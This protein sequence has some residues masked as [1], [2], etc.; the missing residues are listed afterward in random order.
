MRSSSVSLI[1]AA[2]LG[3]AFFAVTPYLPRTEPAK[4]Q[5]VPNENKLFQA[6]TEEERLQAELRV[7]EEKLQAE[8]RAKIGADGYE[9]VRDESP[10]MIGDRVG[11]RKGP[12]L[13]AD[14]ATNVRDM[15]IIDIDVRNE[16]VT[17]EWDVPR[18]T[19]MDR[20]RDAFDMKDL[21]KPYRRVKM[22]P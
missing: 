12:P 3:V 21:K 5:A 8:L 15:R 14:E 22:K 18:S 1:F 16:W 2:I 19:H 10:M 17:V 20:C 4:A 6:G 11:F 7:K 13:Y 9:W